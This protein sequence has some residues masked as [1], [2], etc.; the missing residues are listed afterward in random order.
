[1]G[2]WCPAGWHARRRGCGRVSAFCSAC[3]GRGRHGRRSCRRGRA[4]RAGARCRRRRCGGS[5]VGGCRG[6]C[7]RRLRRGRSSCGRS[8]AGLRLRSCGLDDRDWGTRGRG[9]TRFGPLLCSGFWFGMQ[10]LPDGGEIARGGE[11][12]FRR[13][14]GQKRCWSVGTLVCLHAALAQTGFRASSYHHGNRSG[15]MFKRFSFRCFV[16]RPHSVSSVLTGI[17][18][19]S[20]SVLRIALNDLDRSL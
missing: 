14:C 9:R 18:A 4:W 13:E 6:G 7:R 20:C 2:A 1:M 15:S 17:L 10:L 12:G 8:R 16:A 19:A 5:H 11:E 3:R